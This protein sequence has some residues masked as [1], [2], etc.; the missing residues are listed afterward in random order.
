MLQVIPLTAESA[1]QI[2]TLAIAIGGV[3][4][5]RSATQR[6]VGILFQSEGNGLQLIHLGWHDDFA[7]QAATYDY[8]WIPV[9]GVNEVVQVTIADWL[10]TF[11]VVHQNKIPYSINPFNDSP[12]DS[13]GKLRPLLPGEGFTCA[14]F[15]LWAFLAQ[16]VNLIVADSWLSRD[17][18]IGW[19]QK[20]IHYLRN[21]NPPVPQAHIDAQAATNDR[22]VRFRPEEV[23]GVVGSFD[24][25]P[26]DFKVAI[27]LAEDV[28]KKLNVL[29]A[30]EKGTH[31]PLC[32][33]ADPP[34]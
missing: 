15:V 30:I 26:A 17:S 24:G 29:G 11:W 34:D 25:K 12:F 21:T 8:F 5:T 16:K 4:V 2:P 1:H 20:M 28:W 6:H 10:E 14:T 32:S 22:I 13:S 31:G 18:D 9:I 27:G 23:A 7:C 3:D 19:Q 33:L